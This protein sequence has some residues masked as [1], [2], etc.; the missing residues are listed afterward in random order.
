MGTADL[1]VQNS[2]LGMGVI[3]LVVTLQATGWEACAHLE[4]PGCLPQLSL[5]VGLGAPVLGVWGPP[6]GWGCTRSH[7][8]A[9]HCQVPPAPEWPPLVAWPRPAPSGG[10]WAPGSAGRHREPGS[11]MPQGWGAPLL[12]PGVLLGPGALED[13]ALGA[14]LVGLAESKGSE[15][16]PPTAPR[17]APAQGSSP[18]GHGVHSAWTVPTFICNGWLQAGSLIRSLPT[19]PCPRVPDRTRSVCLPA[20][21]V[22]RGFSEPGPC[23]PHSTSPCLSL[24]LVWSPALVPSQWVASGKPLAI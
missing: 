11:E 23:I 21:E 20:S 22:Q 12:Q 15:M 14:G 24:M 3:M 19:T 6:L 16:Q 17:A 7:R 2:G 1:R 8:Q 9:P 13:W 18:M 5:A 10:C 4:R